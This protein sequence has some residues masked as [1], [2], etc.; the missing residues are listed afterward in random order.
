MQRAGVFYRPVT[1]A[2]AAGWRH[3]AVA[4]VFGLV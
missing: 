1:E 2:T 3:A 4:E